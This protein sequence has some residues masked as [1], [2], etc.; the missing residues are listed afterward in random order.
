MYSR[1]LQNNWMVMYWRPIGRLSR[2]YDVN[3]V[4]IH[5][6]LIGNCLKLKFHLVL[7]TQIVILILIQG[8]Y[9]YVYT[10]FIFIRLFVL[11]NRI[12][13]LSVLEGREREG[14]V[15]VRSSTS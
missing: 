15:N 1:L 8:I 5:E 13:H 7:M 14:E 11:C 2:E 6:I 4:I 3:T 10:V 9:M 12:D